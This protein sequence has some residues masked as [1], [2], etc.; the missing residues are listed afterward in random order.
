MANGA[1]GSIRIDTE[2]DNSGFE[3]GSDK[4]INALNSLKESVDSI[5]ETLS[6]GLNSVIK[7]LQALSSQA[8]TT[9][10]QVTQSGQEAVATNEQIA[11]SANDAAE[12]T[13][14][15]GNAPNNVPATYNSIMRSAQSLYDQI[16]RL[17][18]AADIGFK[19]DGQILRYRDSVDIVT[20]KVEEL[21]DKLAAMG[22]AQIP[23]EDY[24]FLQGELDKAE[25]SLER[26]KTRQDAMDAHGVRESS[27]AYQNLITD[28]ERAERAVGIIKQE[29]SDMQMDGSAFTSGVNTAEYQNLSNVITTLEDKLHGVQQASAEAQMS[30][31]SVGG[32]S[33]ILSALGTA[34]QK[35]ASAFW[36]M[37]RAIGGAAVHLLGA[38]VSKL[39]SGLRSVASGAKKATSKLLGFNSAAKGGINPVNALIRGLTSF[40]RMFITRLKRTFMS[41]IFNEMKE[42][43][44]QFALYS[45]SFNQ[46]MSNIKNTGSQIAA[47]A[48]SLV[49]SVITAIE[50]MLTRLLALINSVITAISAL[51]AKFS[52]KSTV[53]VA[54]KG[55]Q[56]YADSLKNAAGGASKAAKEQKKFNA[57]LYGWDE[58]T[59]QS[60]QDDSDSGG[61]G[62]SGPQWSEVPVDDILKDWEGIDWFQKGY[63]WAEKFAD[64]LDAIPW[65][66]IQEGA[67]KAGTA[68]AQ[69]LNGVFA[70]LHLAKSLG[71]TIAQAFNTAFDFALAF[72]REFNF[73]QFGVWAGTLWNAFVDA[74]DFDD[75]AE[76][77]SRA[78]NGLITALANFF[79]TIE[80][81]CGTFGA[82]LGKIFNAIFADIDLQ[83]LAYSFLLGL[84]DLSLAIKGFVDE[85]K[86]D[87]IANN[88]KT[89][90]NTF[91]KGMVFNQDGEL[92]N[93]WEENGKVVGELIGKFVS[94]IYDIVTGLDYKT[95]G[96]N[97]A[98]WLSNAIQGVDLTKLF[99]IFVQLFNGLVSLIGSF[100][101][102][103]DWKD[104]GKNLVSSLV[105]AIKMID[106]AN[107]GKTVSDLFIG[108]LDLLNGFIEE[109]DWADLG[110]TLLQGF[111]NMLSNIDWVS[112]IGKLFQLLCNVI[113]GAVELLLGAF[114]GLFAGLAEA[115]EGIGDDSVAGFFKG[116][117]DALSNCATW[118]KENVFDPIVNGVK[119][120]FGINSPSTVFAEIGDWL[121]QGLAQ[122]ISEAWHLIT[123]F[124]AEVLG[125]LKQNISDKWNEIK[126]DAQTAYE[127][128]KSEISEKWNNI[129]ETVTTTVDNI[130]QEV[131]TRWNNIKTDV[132]TVM[133]N[134]KQDVSQKWNEAKNDITTAAN[135][136]KTTVTSKFNETKQNVTSSL[137]NMKQSAST[138]WESIKSTATTSFEN[139]RSTV[140]SKMTEAENFLKGL[141]WSSIGTD[142][143]SGLLNGLKEKWDKVKEW[144]SEA[145][146]GLTSKLKSAFEIH[147]PSKVWAQIG[148]FLD[149]GLEEGL[150][151]GERSMYSTAASIASG[152]SNRMSNAT[153]SM[154]LSTDA[155]IDRLNIIETTLNGIASIID[156]IAEALAAMG[157]LEIP[158]IAAGTVVPVR[159]KVS[160]TDIYTGGEG[161]T[162][163]DTEISELV[164]LVRNIRDYLASA[165]QRGGDVKVVVN[166]REIF[167]VVVDENNRAIARTGASPIKV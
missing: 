32:A 14:A 114:S 96:Q 93:V 156:H 39:A 48:A 110:K 106:W 139:V 65:E 143:V 140:Q 141:N 50:P 120:L 10:Q 46:A 111:I 64:A 89:G 91:I 154:T 125:N 21:K 147:S 109:V 38:G 105:N 145:A 129:K 59:K 162:D 75:V 132:S 73:A 8:N 34:A 43:V 13:Q 152:L 134:I 66:S 17:S 11:Q 135:N 24:K 85:V 81:S 104:L 54:A 83:S 131:S 92:V 142:L 118:L 137:T 136:I 70:N 101:R 52:G 115:W 40:K 79:E 77:I 164:Q 128:I 97:I 133:S 3:Q 28:I 47:Q 98:L 69:F 58:L 62:A 161:Y 108:A 87:A 36:A 5:G 12:A 160:P 45:A 18:T 165:G 80:K 76:V 113:S 41:Q 33:P 99:G 31:Q 35:T 144:A 2:L 68:I 74:F 57:E 71:T 150:E 22:S 82:G 138:T 1:D 158:Q 16:T 67:R 119:S 9:N 95:L 153:G 7:S 60:K 151:S 100:V 88:I 159:T 23:T 146:E 123:D 94:T 29:M 117:S 121:I 167:Q 155:D 166:G 163:E 55:T 44:Q 148:M 19:N 112:L 124:F 107:F 26:L 6:D 72:L 37:S 157:G 4:L 103:M 51:F 53:A 27:T 90:I 102:S 149:E 84:H 42:G 63:E 116:I 56:S 86:W 61:G 127:N 49:G 78:G 25:K 15:M 30:M 126:Q 20:R 122:G 130:K